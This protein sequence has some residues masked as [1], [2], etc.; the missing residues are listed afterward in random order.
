MFVSDSRYFL[1]MKLSKIATKFILKSFTNISSKTFLY[2]AQAFPVPNRRK[3]SGYN[4]TGPGDPEES[5]GPNRVV[6]ALSFQVVSLFF[7]VQINPFGLSPSHSATE[8]QPFRFSVN[9][10]TGP[11]LLGNTI[12]FRRDLNLLS[13]SLALSLSE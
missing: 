6:C 12:F 4:L 11:P 3:E 10:L 1:L 2:V 7:I 9:F 5:S 8:S 13:A